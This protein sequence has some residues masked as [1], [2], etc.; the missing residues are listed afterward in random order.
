MSLWI[1]RPLWRDGCTI[2]LALLPALLAFAALRAGPAADPGAVTSP[3]GLD[4]AAP[5]IAVLLEGALAALRSTL[6]LA[7][8]LALLSIWRPLRPAALP[9]VALGAALAATQPDRPS[10]IA[11]AL[12]AWPLA[13][14]LA[15]YLRGNLAALLLGLWWAACLPNALALL[16]LD[17][18]WYAVNG[19]LAIVALLV[20]IL[21]LRL[22]AG[23]AG[24]K[25]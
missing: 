22:E 2:G 8:A 18:W 13:L 14:L 6:L 21:L 16:A 11:L 4:S 19:A 7:G 20:P 1:D 10:M 23:A 3:R 9:L 5:A 24:P 17:Q 12:L 25:P 15:R